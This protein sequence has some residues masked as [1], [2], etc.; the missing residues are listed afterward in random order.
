[1]TPRELDQIR[2]FTGLY[3]RQQW[4]W[5]YSYILGRP[6]SGEEVSE[7][8]RLLWDEYY[9]AH[10]DEPR[11]PTFATLTR[12]ETPLFRASVERAKTR[13]HASLTKLGSSPDETPEPR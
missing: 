5:L 8:H 6:V 9:A 7:A 12:S 13:H 3:S 11:P 2:S 10:P 4:A 1:M